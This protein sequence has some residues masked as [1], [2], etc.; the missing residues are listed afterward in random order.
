MSTFRIATSREMRSPVRVQEWNASIRAGDDFKLASTIYG[1]DDGSPAVVTNSHSLLALWHEG[2][3][4]HSWDYGLGWWTGGSPIPGVGAPMIQSP[5][6][7]TSVRQGGINFSLSGTQT[8]TL[9]GR[10][11][12]VMLIDLPDG[13]FTQ[14]EGYI[15]VR[16]TRMQKGVPLLI[17]TAQ[18]FFQLDVSQLD[19]GILA[20]LI[21]NGV[22]VDQDG[23]PLL[24]ATD[25]AP[26]TPGGDL[27]VDALTQALLGLPTTL[28]AAS[29]VLWW[30][31]GILALS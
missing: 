7:V 20:A 3:H 30:D 31:G 17:H 25:G 6:F 2:H 1:D 4:P 8:A 14:F 15:Q 26:V 10:Y 22:P 28:P 18:A 5:G 9:W 23:F 21:D 19:V 12:L 24:V 11:R 13:S 16:P 29:G 27:T